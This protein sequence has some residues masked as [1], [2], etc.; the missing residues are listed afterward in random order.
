MDKNTGC[1][2]N[3]FLNHTVSTC[4]FS[5]YEF[6]IEVSFFVLMEICVVIW[7]HER[8]LSRDERGVVVV[9]L[10]DQPGG[11]GEEDINPRY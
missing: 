6:S 2:L 7:I 9:Y 3:A 8:L 11:V 10:Q 4:L 5:K 1:T